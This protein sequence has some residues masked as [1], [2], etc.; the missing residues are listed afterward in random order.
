MVITDA[1]WKVQD[2]YPLIGNS[3]YQPEG[4]AFDAEGNLYISN[5]G[6][7]LSDGNVLKFI[8]RTQ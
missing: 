7:E 3:F 5:E 6:D 4:I 2:V 8:R 1:N